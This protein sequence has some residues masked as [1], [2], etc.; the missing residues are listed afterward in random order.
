VALAVRGF[1]KYKSVTVWFINGAGQIEL[2][3]IKTS[4]TGSANLSLSAHDLANWG[5]RWFTPALAAVRPFATTP[6]RIAG[7]ASG[8]TWGN[9][10]CAAGALR[11]HYIG[12]HEGFHHMLYWNAKRR[13]S[14]AMVSNN[15]LSPTLQQR[16]QRAIVAFV[17]R[18]S[19]RGMHEIASRFAGNDIRVGSYRTAGGDLAIVG[20]ARRSGMTVERGGVAYVAYPIGSGV[21]YVP[22]LDAYLA[23]SADGT[24]RWLT[25]YEELGA[26]S[27][28][29]GSEKPKRKQD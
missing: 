16:L 27:V 18:R 10:Y 6:A 29:S 9:W 8:L 4:S 13:I 11:C 20:P 2:A 1:R 19:A 22:G 25:L 14:V 23:A 15:S 3:T 21:R 12:H 24:L 26:V 17:E 28:G 5:A 7:R